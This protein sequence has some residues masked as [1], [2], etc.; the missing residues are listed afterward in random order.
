MLQ[1]AHC[2]G[3][4][5]R[6]PG[7]SSPYA[8]LV[9]DEEGMPHLPLT[10]FYKKM[11]EWH[12]DGTARTYL[13]A[14]RPYFLYLATDEWRRHRGDQW[15]SEPEAV[16]ESVRDYLMERL[17][18]KV[19]PQATHAQVTL[20]VQSPNTV[21]IFLAALKQFYFVMAREG[22]YPY[23]NPL[24][25]AASRLLRELEQE[26]LNE[27]RHMPQASGVEAPR[28]DYP[29]EN[30]FRL[31]K[32]DWQVSPVD[33]P[34]LGKTLVE[35][36]TKAGLC[37]RDQIVVRMALETGARISETLHLT[38]GDWRVLGCN[39]EVRAC[40]KGSWGRRVKT[41]RF[42]ATTARMLRQYLN[43]DRVTLDPLGRRL[44]QLS[45]SDPLFLSQR[46]K[47][48]GYEALKPHWY[49]LCATVK[50]DLNIHALRHWYT[51]MSIRLIV[52]EAKSNADITVGKEKLVRYMAWRSHETLRTYE[53]YFK[54]IGHY[55][56]QDRV[57]QSLEKDVTSYLR[58]HDENSSRKQQRKQ[59]SQEGLT[60]RTPSSSEVAP[61][62][63]QPSGWAKLL[64]L[65][66]G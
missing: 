49:K 11:A 19:R 40:N 41:L 3:I 47:P 27:R 58:Q 50:L 26:A 55:K 8:L 33:D 18:C 37:L 17:G 44:E 22:A 63:P 36:F 48:Y 38:V 39:Q 45:D 20:T 25:D 32:E 10:V 53:N 54:S 6:P 29:S 5:P 15:N 30:F 62:T 16:Q 43:T 35:G 7:V 64:A 21:H 14:L 57:H 60:T 4:I 12:A 65:G 42:S 34:T 56:I 1:I 13:N 66:G 23:T 61:K 51:T 31:T 52:E 2:F 9:V 59:K 28:T 46:R 24:L